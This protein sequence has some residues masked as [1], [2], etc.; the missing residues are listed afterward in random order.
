[1]VKLMNIVLTDNTTI[2]RPPLIVELVGP[3]GAGKTTLA[4]ALHQFSKR[5]RTDAP[6]NYRRIEHVPFFA[7]NI[8]GLMPTFFHMYRNINGRWL[9]R[10]EMAWMVILRGWH[11]MLGKQRSTNDTVVVLDQGPVFLL[12][13]LYGFGPERLKSQSAK[14]WWDGMYKQWANSLD[15]VIWLDTLD[16]TLVE[17]IRAR[18]KWHGNK[19]RSDPEAFEFLARWRAAYAQVLSALT[20]EATG[21][22]LLRFDTAQKCPDEIVNR[23]LAVFCFTDCQDNI[24]G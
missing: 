16:T 6:P 4:Q 15:M 22:K 17:R 12:A 9:T 13:C 24:V 23:V 14:K 1:M 11:Q 2:K 3:A 7:R 19:K 21:P 18:Y 8:L 20:A 5:I 10:E